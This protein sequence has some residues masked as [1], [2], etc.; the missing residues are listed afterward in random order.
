MSIGRKEVMLGLVSS[1]GWIRGAELGVWQGDLLAFLLGSCPALHMIGVDHWRQEGA[2]EKSKDTGN[3]PYA[4]KDMAGAEAKAR[5][6]VAA[7]PQRA[8]ILKMDT[9][10]A[11]SNVT[12]ASLDFIFASHDTESV[13]KDIRSWRSKV[14][15]GG[16]LTGHDANWPSVTRALDAELPGWVLLEGNVWFF[17]K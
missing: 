6:A 8:V 16:A 2:G 9:V 7:F 11:A 15:L 10:A 1:R 13:T 3:A 17:Q 4:G 14:K 5:A 12:D